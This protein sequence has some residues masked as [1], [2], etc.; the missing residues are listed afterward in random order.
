MSEWFWTDA[1]TLC[2]EGKGFRDTKGFYHRLPARAEG[3]VREARWDLS[4]KTTGITVRFQTNAREIRARWTLGSEPLW[5][6]HTPLFAYSGLDLYA[7]TRDG[8]WHWAGMARDITGLHA[9]CSLTDWGV[10]DGETHEYRLYLPLYNS[11]EKLEIGIPPGSSIRST[12]TRPEKPVVYYGTSIVH[13]A[14][15]SRPGMSHVALLGRR[16][17]YPVWNLGFSGNAI[18][19]PEVAELIAELDPAAYI[20]DSLPNMGAAAVTE[21]A[22]AFVSTLRAAH[23]DTPIILVE[24]RTYPAGWL[25]PKLAEEN[26]TRRAA[27]KQVYA[28]LLAAEAASGRPCRLFYLEGDGL[29]GVDNDG[30][31]DGSHCNDLGS[32][33]MVD[34]LEPVLRRVLGLHGY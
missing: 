24:D 21:R 34:A 7:K 20:L 31:N 30:T 22:E 23:P 13:G 9:E 14:G 11:V 25:A 2:V 12:L 18:M 10:L 26:V 32:A 17:D 8:R 16:L 5:A 15:V 19:E 27:F 33:R 4:K 1:E 6:P 29:L 28:K 3:K